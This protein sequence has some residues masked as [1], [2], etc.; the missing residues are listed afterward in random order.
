MNPPAELEGIRAGLPTPRTII[1]RAMPGLLAMAG[2]LCSPAPAAEQETPW[3]EQGKIR[4]FWGQ[5]GRF[6]AFDRDPDLTAAENY[7]ATF[8]RETEIMRNVRAAGAT[9]F[10][11]SGCLT[12]QLPREDGYHYQWGI[13]LE[14][15]A[16]YVPGVTPHF[17]RRGALAHEQGLKYFAPL[18]SC[19]Y[20]P[21]AKRIGARLAVNR[22]GR[23]ALEEVAAGMTVGFPPDAHVPCPLDE[24]VA[25]EWLL[26]T[27]LMA[28]E[29][30]LDGLHIDWETYGLTGYDQC[31]EYLCYCEFCFAEFAAARDVVETPARP[32]RYDWLKSCGLHRAYLENRRDA[33]AALYRRVAEQVRA[34]KPDFIFSAYPDFTPGEWESYYGWRSEGAALGLHSA[35]APFFVVD[36]S[37]YNPNVAAP[38]WETG[39]VRVKDLGMKHI[40]GSWTGTW[41]GHLPAMQIGAAQW[42]YEAAMS[43][44]GYWFWFQTAL[45]PNNYRA[46][47]AADMAIGAVEA[48]AGQFLTQGRQDNTFLCLAEQSGDPVL[49]YRIQQ[50]AYR[51]GNRSLLWVLNTDTER[52]VDVLARLSRLPE[53]R[54]WTVTDLRSRLPFTLAGSS[55]WTT[56]DLAAGLLLTLGKRSDAWVIVEP[57]AAAA[58]DGTAAR[59]IPG[60]VIPAHPKRVALESGGPDVG[61]P[62]PGLTVVFTRWTARELY[63]SDP[64]P[65]GGTTVCVIDASAPGNKS[66]QLFDIDG[67][68]RTPALSPDR[69]RVAYSCWVNGKAQI[70]VVNTDGANPRNLSANAWRDTWPVWAPDGQRLAFLSDRAGAWQLCVMDADGSRQT[71]LTAG[72][73][74]VR[75]PAWAPDGSRIAFV[76]NRDG[77]FNLYTVG[78]NGSGERLLLSRAGNVYEPAWAPDGTRIACTAGI[79]GSSR[80]ILVMDAGTG[81]VEH[82][83]GVT[84]AAKGWWQYTNIRSIRW[85]PNGTRIAGAFE[86]VAGWHPSTKGTAGVFVATLGQTAAEDVAV[87]RGQVPGDSAE[88]AAL[89]ELVS[90]EPDKLKPGGSVARYKLVGAW[91]W[92][93][94]ASRHWLTRR[95]AAVHWSPDGERLLFRSDMDPSGYEF[96]YTINAD[97]SDLIRLDGSQDPS[98]PNDSLPTA[99]ATDSGAAGSGR[100][101]VDTPALSRSFD[102]P[103]YVA[104][105]G[106]LRQ[107]DSLPVTGWKF[108]ADPEGAGTERGYWQ[109]DYPDEEMQDIRVDKFWDNQGHPKLQQ[110]WYRLRYQCPD[111]PEGKRVFLRFGAVDEAAWLYVDGVLSA[112]YK[113]TRPGETW[114]KPV[115]LEV[116]GNLVPGRDHLLTVRVTNASGAGGLWQP[117]ALL[118]AE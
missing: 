76:S 91:Y 102:G 100:R 43:H 67:Y 51:L 9:V 12:N 55:T 2:L 32:Q 105:V 63:G 80:D 71:Q 118:V 109:Q 110:G 83:L 96:L 81:A 84:Y 115:L 68:C 86:R 42:M 97:G 107:V 85:S 99:D 90:V 62:L 69:T 72:P 87:V 88:S 111:L 103:D 19:N 7:K 5:W 4:F 75:D 35:S 61:P 37:H 26:R 98:G 11:D 60:D 89:R 1:L 117:A 31:G 65:V 20:R 106:R 47:R 78:A 48:G 52:S 24:R 58:G 14:G 104:L 8:A 41:F 18:N 108:L 114:D 66:R 25:D 3:W 40:L 45:A 101:A 13:Y 116:T 29:A 46:F 36:A 21:I 17:F 92:N 79:G 95:F 50:R 82:P 28:A 93:G 6:D 23:T 38:W 73:G 27:A 16:Y 33:L 64:N 39:H 94:D 49:G 59:G 44:D 34:V 15:G 70:Y 57:S 77:D 56:A 113:P 112:W 74:E 22:H 30:G 10:V 53:N 54:N